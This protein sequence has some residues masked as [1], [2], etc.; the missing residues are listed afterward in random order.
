[1]RKKKT[2]KDKQADLRRRYDAIK[3]LMSTFA[4]STV[5][6]VA[7]VTL[8]PASPKA[9]IIKTVALNEEIVYQVEVTDKDNAL[10]ESTLFVVL[11][12]QLEYYEEPISL[13]EH[14]GYFEN[15]NTN[16]QY[17]LSV[18]GDKGFGQERLATELITTR[19]KIGGTILGVTPIT[20]MHNTIYEVDIS[21]YDPDN[22]Y[23]TV[24]LYYGEQMEPDQEIQYHSIAVTSDKMEL[25]I[26]DIWSEQLFHIYL[27]ATTSDG[28]QQLDE[29]W[30]TPPYQMYASV[31]LWYK[32]STEL[33]Y[34]IYEDSSTIN[35]RYEATVYIKNI[36]MKTVTYT[37]DPTEHHGGLLIE[38]LAPETEYSVEITAYYTNPQT[39]ATEHQVLLTE[40]IETTAAF[41][42]TYQVE[43][44]DTY[45]LITITLEDPDSLINQL[46]YEVLDTS[47]EFDSYLTSAQLPI[48]DNTITVEIEKPLTERYKIS[49]Q[50]LNTN[51]YMIQKSVAT[52]E[53]E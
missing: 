12:N 32:N 14:S 24:T 28:V 37:P 22:T 20:D 46:M 2:R 47:G 16:T 25:Q 38:G 1:M 41:S 23:T 7:A 33:M 36:L 48:I 29:I 49:I 5:A 34:S 10:D 26:N 15:L 44:F 27:E 18:Y 50:I 3:N 21:I 35:L 4:M 43:E 40:D 17:R 13:G 19:V 30:V 42:Y 8:I 52:I 39:L 31:E 45:Y 51:D 53:I 9:E 6:V 11:E